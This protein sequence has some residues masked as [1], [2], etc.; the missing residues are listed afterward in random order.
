MTF[1]CCLTLSSVAAAPENLAEVLLAWMGR[2]MSCLPGTRHG[3][4]RYANADMEALEAAL[5]KHQDKR[6]RLITTAG[7]FSMDG[8]CAPLEA[9]CDLAD[10]RTYTI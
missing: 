8:I 9:I 10:R 7:I 1:C 4:C 6:T 3:A 2:F 5:I